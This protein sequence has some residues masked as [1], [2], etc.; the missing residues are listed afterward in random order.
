[1]STTDEQQLVER[2]VA[3]REETVGAGQSR[4]DE[5]VTGGRRRVRRRRAAAMVP[6]LALTVVVGGLAL[7][8]RGLPGGESAPTPPASS[9]TPTSATTTPFVSFAG[10]TSQPATC[11]AGVVAQWFTTTIDGL[12]PTGTEAF[13][14]ATTVSNLDGFPEGTVY[15]STLDMDG[16][17][18]VDTSQ[19]EKA[20][21]PQVQIYVTAKGS[22]SRFWSAEPVEPQDKAAERTV[23]VRPGL[24]ARVVTHDSS[25]SWAVTEGEG[26]GAVYLLVQ[27]HPGGGGQSLTD[28]EVVD[29]LRLLLEDPKVAAG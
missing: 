29:L 6:A 20:L 3:A 15:F 2:V 14:D 24:D 9:S 25:S 17:V 27:N 18:D 28:D 4:V 19:D 22:D 1:M 16:S 8:V 23:E 13:G 11:D 10:C 26:H 5:V 12:S 7:G 21:P